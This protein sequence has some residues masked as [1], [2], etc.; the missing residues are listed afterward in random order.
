MQVG[1][2]AVRQ[3]LLGIAV[4]VGAVT[5]G[6]G[7]AP[8]AY[9]GPLEDGGAAYDKGDYATAARLYKLAADQLYAAAQDNL[10]VMYSKGAGVTQNYILAHMWH[11]LAAASSLEGSI[12]KNATTNRDRVAGK[13]TPAQIEPRAEHGAGVSGIQLQDLRVLTGAQDRWRS[14]RNGLAA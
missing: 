6:L 11:N 1:P 14:N 4:T 13:M 7:F 9:A 2:K 8:S 5:V 12:R 3:V 10:G